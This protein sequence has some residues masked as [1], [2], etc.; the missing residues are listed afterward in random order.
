MLA[1]KGQL[2]AAFVA[3]RQHCINTRLS[4]LQ[5]IVDVEVTELMD[6]TQS[7]GYEWPDMGALKHPRGGGR[8]VVARSKVAKRG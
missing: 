3:P 6:W 1:K 5:A 7:A 8:S 2:G 4:D